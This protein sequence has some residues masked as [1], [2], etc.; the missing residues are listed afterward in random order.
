MISRLRAALPLAGTP[1]ALLDFPAFATDV[2]YERT[3]L[4]TGPT[5]VLGRGWI[6]HLITTLP[7]GLGWAIY[8]AA[9]AGIVVLALRLRRQALPLAL[10][11]IAFYVSMGAG[12]TVFF[13]YALPLLPIACACAAVA[14][15]AVAKRFGAHGR[16]AAAALAL[17]VALPSFAQSAALD[18]LLAKR[19]SR[20][21]AAEWLAARL[22]PDDTLHDS[23]GDYTRLSLGAA[24][25]HA[26]R[27]DA[28]TR[29][30]GD[31]SGAIPGWIVL[32]ESPLPE[33]TAAPD[34]LREL[35]AA[36]YELAYRIDG[37]PGRGG[38]GVYD[39]QD[40]F[41][42]PIAGFKAVARPGPTV[43]IYKRR[44]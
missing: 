44:S 21:I 26:W 8:A 28:A 3:H 43:L 24:R 17:I 5:V 11:A 1:F 30:F 31:P 13:R 7:Y 4:A 42:L 33:Y 14:V 34:S 23:G 38:N 2:S 32:Y 10:F 19:D 25:F 36:R 29:T 18:R 22:Q 35:V 41:F 9:A 16:L 20:V 12:F 6:Y 27:Y 37:V 39:R 40:A 15:C